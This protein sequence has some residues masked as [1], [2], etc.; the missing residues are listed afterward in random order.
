MIDLQ[1]P[2]H[3]PFRLVMRP[4]SAIGF[5]SGVARVDPIDRRGWTYQEELISTRHIKIT[6]DDIRW[7]CSMG[8][9]CLCGFGADP[10]SIVQF[11]DMNSPGTIQTWNTIVEGFFQR[12]LTVHTD[13]L[14]AISSVARKFAPQIQSKYQDSGGSAVDYYASI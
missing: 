2:I 14:L 11:D 6:A 5:H 8:T 7:K 4:A 12:L 1:L 10:V 3:E 13:K 9:T